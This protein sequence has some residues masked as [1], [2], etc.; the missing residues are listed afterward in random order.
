MLGAIATCGW[1]DDDC[2]DEDSGDG[3]AKADACADHWDSDTC[4]ADGANQCRWSRAHADHEVRIY[5]YVGRHGS[6][7]KIEGPD[8]S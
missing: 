2:K 4:D 3:C 8:E 6:G 1:T 5:Y 7:W